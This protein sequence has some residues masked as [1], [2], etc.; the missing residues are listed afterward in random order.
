MV[1]NKFFQEAHVDWLVM[2]FCLQFFQKTG[3]FLLKKYLSF[4]KLVFSFKLAQN[5]QEVLLTTVQVFVLLI[6]FLASQGEINLSCFDIKQLVGSI[7]LLCSFIW[8]CRRWV[9]SDLLVLL[10]LRLR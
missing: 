1:L 3:H 10:S 6:Y 9:R 8:T 7:V 2:M 4:L 5:D